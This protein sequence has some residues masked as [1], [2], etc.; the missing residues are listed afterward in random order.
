MT[1]SSTN[2]KQATIFNN[3]FYMIKARQMRPESSWITSK[4]IPRYTKVAIWIAQNKAYN[5]DLLLLSSRISKLVRDNGFSWTFNYLKESLRLVTR[6]LAGNGEKLCTG[7]CRVRLDYRGLPVIIPFPIRQVLTLENENVTIVRATLTLISIFRTFKVTVKPDLSSITDPFSGL[8]RTLEL[9]DIPLKFSKGFKINF[10]QVRGFISE[11]AGPNSSKATSGS[12]FDAIALMSNPMALSAVIHV[13]VSTRSWLYLLSLFLTHVITAPFIM[14]Q[15]LYILPKYKMGR[16]SVVYDQAGKAR[17]VAITNYWIQLCLLPLHNSIFRLLKS[18]ETDGTFNQNA[19]IERLL[20][21]NIKN[22]KF[23]CFDLTAATDRI[24]I[25]LQEDILRI[26]CKSRLMA[27]TWRLL[28][29]ISW[30]YKGE[31]IKYSVGQ[32]MGAYSSWAMLALTHHIIV[33]L[34]SQRAGYKKEFSHYAVLGD[35]IVIQND[36][37]AKHYLDIMET[38]GVCIN[39][40]KSVVSTDLLEFAKRLRTRTSDI[41]PVG[42]GAI[43]ATARRPLMAGILFTDL[44]QRGI[45]LLSDAFKTYI[46]TFPFKVKRI[47]VVLSMFGIRGHLK[48]LYQLDV[49]TLSWISSVELIDHTMFKRA[50]REHSLLMSIEAASSAVTASKVEYNYFINNFFRLSSGKTKIDYLINLLT[51]PVA[52]M[53]WLYLE[54]I[55]RS[56][57]E[58]ED[59]LEELKA[60]N[61][62]SD[63]EMDTILDRLFTQD[64]SNISIRWN[65]RIQRKY[66]NKV[67]ALSA[68]TLCSMINDYY[69]SRGLS[70][71][72]NFSKIHKGL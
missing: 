50:L 20:A 16:L 51:I 6:Y 42:P 49:E 41:S 25:D 68:S 56:L 33:Q 19:P 17:I 65:R 57:V 10:S 1:L 29:D 21:L 54:S 58:T 61:P 36:K 67:K 24:P 14:A 64:L 39:P 69:K 66:T 60:I 55:I 59:T 46:K 40:T 70:H 48:S 37:V 2:I 44:D 47:G 45:I 7:K 38:L 43:L 22:H 15:W 31:N 9:G 32:P 5:E 52:P 53:M 12:V 23:S 27:K 4:E 28:L 3:L 18:K 34:A 62:D 35:D 8:S 63:D 72:A 11:S 13:L 71:T 30:H 26:V